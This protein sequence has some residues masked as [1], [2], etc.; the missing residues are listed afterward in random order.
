MYTGD[1]FLLHVIIMFIKSHSILSCFTYCHDPPSWYIVNICT[2]E[3]NEQYS[4]LLSSEWMPCYALRLEALFALWEDHFYIRASMCP[5]LA[6]N[7]SPC[8][9]GM[10]QYNLHGKI[11]VAASMGIRFL[12]M[13]CWVCYKRTVLLPDLDVY[14]FLNRLCRYILD[15]GLL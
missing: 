12:V 13:T 4:W 15:I 8:R 6:E 1:R 5:Q 11:G 3:N 7:K 14:R 2:V 9:G 10:W